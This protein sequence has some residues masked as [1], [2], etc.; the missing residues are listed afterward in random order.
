M[1]KYCA[2]LSLC[3]GLALPGDF[4]TGQAAR[5]IIGQTTFT[6]QNNGGVSGSGPASDTVVGAVSGLAYANGILFVTDANRLGLLPVNNRVLMYN[7]Q[8]NVPPLLPVLP[9]NSRC[10][11]CNSQAS[12]VL[13]QPD[14]TTTTATLTQSGMNLPLAVASDGTHVAVADT[15]N[16]RVLIWNSIPTQ[17]GQPADVV[18]GQKDFTTTGPV[19]VT[20][21]TFRAP[22]GVWFQGGKFFVADTQNNRVLIWNTI[23]KQNNQAA[24]VV[25]GAP[26][27]T[28]IPQIDQ[29]KSSLQSAANIL[30]TP[31]SVTSDGTHVV[32]A[33][34]GFSRVLIWNTIPTQNNQPADVV[35]GQVDMV[36]SIPNDSFNGSPATSSTDTTN[37]ETPALCNLSN[38]TDAAN[39]PVYPQRCAAT[40]DFPRFALTDGTRLYVAD[41]GNDRVLIWN[42][43][44]TQNGQPADVVIGEP[45]AYSDNVSSNFG[46][47]TPNLEQSGADITPTPGALAWDGTNL[48]VS[49]PSN[50]RVL[51]FTPA[52][53]DVQPNGVVNAAS[54]AIY[55]LG[56]ITLGGTSGTAGDKIT[57]TINGTN[58]S[59]TEVDKDTF[60]MVLKALANAINQSNS[61][62]GDP[63]VLAVPQYGY[64]ILQLVARAP[65]AAGNNVTLATTVSTNA[66]ITSVASGGSLFGGSIPST[67]AAGALIS[68]QGQN[69][70]D[71]TQPVSADPSATSLPTTLANVQVYVD[72]IQSPLM[73]VSPTQINAQ[74]PWEVVDTNSSN[75][76]VRVQHA[77]GSVTVTDAIGLPI[78]VANPGLFAQPGTDPRPGIAFHGSSYATA[79]VSVDGSVADG[80]TATVTVEDRTYTYKVQSNTTTTDT[81]STVRDGLIALINANPEEKVIASAAAAYTRIRLRAK[82]PG[83]DGDNIQIGA[84]SA[85]SSGGAGSVVMTALNTQLCC[86]NREGAAITP[87]NPATAGETIYLYGTGLGLVC[88]INIQCGANDPVK[89]AIVDGAVYTGS[90]LN[91]PISPVSALIGGNTATVVSA[92]LLPGTVGVYKV[93]LELGSAVP[94]SPY[95]Q[96]TISQSIYTSNIV[97]IAVVNPA[98]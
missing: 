23:P 87:D 42:T 26:N 89:A 51:V 68:I 63:N 73:M 64:G 33:D 75:L 98:Q 55:A 3:A 62:A 19:V 95:T 52:E 82:V 27:F 6:S 59:Y 84:T 20:A 35:L 74:V 4:I 2:A 92:G 61:G 18:L 67:L 76:Y 14:F 58:Y 96:V 1:L 41:S 46:L 34:L 22:Q 17:N 72:G 43:F 37:K 85:S 29:T 36:T 8:S 21:S 48:Y 44:P 49:D 16:N 97:V 93:V 91:N 24:D 15:D 40:M 25:L 86:A 83:P 81:L 88:D 10:P 90:P 11:V 56:T 78:D 65:G 79:T 54:L 28:T 53:G 13:G 9:D 31:I 71:C 50:Y 66:Q 77:D 57:V 7:V 69:L 47:F 39:N 38:G 45:D 80:D 12:V 94:S 5:A 32:V 70:C 60:D 30:L